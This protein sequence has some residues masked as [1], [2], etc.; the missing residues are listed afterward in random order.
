MIIS[1]ILVYKKAKRE[2]EERE[3]KRRE[4]KR[5]FLVEEKKKARARKNRELDILYSS[6]SIHVQKKK[7]KHIY[8]HCR[9]SYDILDHDAN[10]FFSNF[11]FLCNFNCT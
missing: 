2:R 4:E 6:H 5:E 3:E 10:N 8:E 11:Y 9:I 1:I 7:Q